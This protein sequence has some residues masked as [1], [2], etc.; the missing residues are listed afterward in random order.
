M[1]NF[2]LRKSA[3]VGKRYGHLMLQVI[4]ICEVVFPAK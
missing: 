3:R 1:R 4:V 2:G